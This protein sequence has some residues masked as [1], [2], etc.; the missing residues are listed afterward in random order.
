VET[1][2]LSGHVRFYYD[3]GSAEAYLAAERS[4]EVLGVVPEWVPVRMDT[5]FRCAEEVASHREDVERSAARY[6]LAPV[7]WPE[8]F[9]FD[10]DFAMLA[11]TYALSIGRGV[12]FSLAAFRQAFAGGRDLSV[13]ANVLIAG[14]ACELHPAALIKGAELRSTRERLEEATAAARAA[15]VRDVP[16][17]QVG[18]R[19]FHGDRSLEAASA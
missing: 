15:G 4:H 1:G 10:S 14:A 17:V 6:G 5:A 3:L 8:P 11:A 9:P 13:R 19:I 16:A 12:A 7:R 2:S 18:E